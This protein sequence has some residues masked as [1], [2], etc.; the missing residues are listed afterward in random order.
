MTTTVLNIKISKV[1]NKIP[2]TSSLVTIT[3]LNTKILEIENKIP[4]HVKHI[5]TQECN[6]SKS[7]NFAARLKQANL[8]NKLI[9]IIN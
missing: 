5:T 1:E 2:D 8:V 7:E 6:K 9:L 4:D 3:V